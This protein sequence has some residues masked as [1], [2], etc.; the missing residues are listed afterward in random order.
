MNLNSNSNSCTSTENTKRKS[1]ESLNKES[2]EM[3]NSIIESKSFLESQSLIES[4][5][6]TFNAL[7]S[8]RPI[9]PF[10]ALSLKMGEV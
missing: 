7:E 4:Q 3:S 5:S 1:C 2:V 6:Q 8:D 10:L 9:S